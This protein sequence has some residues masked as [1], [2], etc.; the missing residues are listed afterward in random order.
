VPGVKN[1]VAGS[2]GK[3]GAILVVARWVDGEGFEDRIPLKLKVG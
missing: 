1:Q 2:S 3:A